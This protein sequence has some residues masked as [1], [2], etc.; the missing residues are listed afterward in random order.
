M[1]LYYI[2]YEV[3]KTEAGCE[4]HIC[5]SVCPAACPTSKIVWMNLV[6]ILFNDAFLMSQTF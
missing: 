2:T 4:S 1:I 3:L 6:C 5:M